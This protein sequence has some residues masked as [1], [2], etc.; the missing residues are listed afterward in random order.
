MAS[1]YLDCSYLDGS[2]KLGKAQTRV[3]KIW[4]KCL[5][6]SALHLV[7]PARIFSMDITVG[8][9]QRQIAVPK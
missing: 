8:A 4:L 3:A 5:K 1:R 9:D 7:P 6:I 2:V